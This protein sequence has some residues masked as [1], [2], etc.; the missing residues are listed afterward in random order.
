MRAVISSE[1]VWEVEEGGGDIDFV[2]PDALDSVRSTS[3]HQ[4]SST[5][6]LMPVSENHFLSP[7]GT[8]NWTEG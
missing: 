6:F 1:E 3:S 7:L 4:S 8:R 5:A 2:S